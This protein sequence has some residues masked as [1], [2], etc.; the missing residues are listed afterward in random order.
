MDFIVALVQLD[1]EYLLEIRRHQYVEDS[2]V[3]A[4]FIHFLKKYIAK[5]APSHQHNLFEYF[6]QITVRLLI[7][8]TT[9]EFTI[10]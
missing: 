2:T 9:S 8:Y 6:T 4:S 3:V 1:C 10:I 5:H 7:Y